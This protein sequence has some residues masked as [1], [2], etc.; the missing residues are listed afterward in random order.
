ML[1]HLNGHNLAD[2][3]VIDH[4]FDCSIVRRI[5][6]HV[7][8]KH[9]AVVLFCGALYF[10]QLFNV[11][12]NRFFQHHIVAAIQ[13][14]HRRTIMQLIHRCIDDKVAFGTHSQKR[15]QRVKQLRIAQSIALLCNSALV[16]IWFD[17]T[18]HFHFLWHFQSI[19]AVHLSPITI[20]NN[21]SLLLCTGNILTVKRLLHATHILFILSQGAIVSF[22]TIKPRTKD[23]LAHRV[24]STDFFFDFQRLFYP[25]MVNI[26]TKFHPKMLMKRR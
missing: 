22:P 14:I 20:S 10:Q 9:F 5:T 16:G 24:A 11:V 4:V 7:A 1:V 18:D 21:Y 6:Q 2:F 12:D 17:D 23:N 26:R 8:N 25:Y 3:A 19:V 13:N 15:I